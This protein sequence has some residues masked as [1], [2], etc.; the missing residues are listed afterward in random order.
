MGLAD[1][2]DV[3]INGQWRIKKDFYTLFE[4]L[5]SLCE[6]ENLDKEQFGRKECN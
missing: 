6:M 4:Q 1:K 5:M 2:L 3:E